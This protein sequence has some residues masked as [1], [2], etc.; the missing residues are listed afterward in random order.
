LKAKYITA[1]VAIAISCAIAL[2]VVTTDIFVSQNIVYAEDA[3]LITI[4]IATYAVMHASRRRTL[5]DL[6][7]KYN[8]SSSTIEILKQW[9]IKEKSKLHRRTQTLEERDLAERMRIAYEREHQ[10]NAPQ[11]NS[12]F[13]NCESER[14]EQLQRQRLLP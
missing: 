1:I 2:T 13:N 9:Y 11:P 8:L 4:V 14:L 10:Y 3:A 6:A 5:T 7:N 12:I